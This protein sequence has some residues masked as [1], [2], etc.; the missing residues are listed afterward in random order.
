[1][2]CSTRHI[3]ISEVSVEIILAV[4]KLSVRVPMVKVSFAANLACTWRR[5]APTVKLSKTVGVA[6]GGCE[7]A[8]VRGEATVSLGESDRERLLR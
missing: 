4:F 6:G 7:C 8:G 3:V 2:L 1:M 5:M